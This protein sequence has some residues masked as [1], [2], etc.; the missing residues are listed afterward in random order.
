MASRQM[1]HTP[2]RTTV[3]RGSREIHE[4]GRD[5]KKS[6]TPLGTI[7]HLECIKQMVAF[8]LFTVIGNVGDTHVSNTDAAVYREGGCQVFVEAVEPWA[9]NFVHQFRHTNN[10]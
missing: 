5:I 1:G 9:I 10:I 6:Q 4:V 7:H 8:F 3:T 2:T